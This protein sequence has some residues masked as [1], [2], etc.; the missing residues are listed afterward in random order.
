MAFW[1][2]DISSLVDQKDLF[3]LLIQIV[4]LQITQQ[5][6]VKEKHFLL[7]CSKCMQ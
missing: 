1:G 2:K 6:V 7:M 3:I 4:K 5:N